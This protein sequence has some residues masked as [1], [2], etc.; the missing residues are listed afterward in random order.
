MRGTARRRFDRFHH[1]AATTHSLFFLLDLRND[2]FR[3]AQHTMIL[4]GFQGTPASD[5]CSQYGLICR[6][7]DSQHAPPASCRTSGTVTPS[8][9]LP[10]AMGPVHQS[11]HSTDRSRTFHYVKCT[12]C[13]HFCPAD[14]GVGVEIYP[15]LSNRVGD[16]HSQHNQAFLRYQTCHWD[17]GGGDNCDSFFETTFLIM[18]LP[19][20][21]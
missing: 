9:R 13:W 2:S 16:M 7:P 14:V 18:A 10:S 4:R 1:I 15:C 12:A 8:A 11:G 6:Q 19:F 20:Y 3:A 17:P 21:L 5:S